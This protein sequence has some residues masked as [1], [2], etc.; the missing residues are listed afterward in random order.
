MMS[1]EEMAALDAFLIKRIQDAQEEF[2]RTDQ[3]VGQMAFG[4]MKSPKMKM[5]A[6]KGF[7]DKKPQQL[8]LADYINLCEALGLN[9]AKECREALKAVKAAGKGGWEMTSKDIESQHGKLLNKYGMLKTV[10]SSGLPASWGLCW[11]IRRGIN[12]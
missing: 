1:F 7:G 12:F 6:I 9:W 11:N 2:K 4:W 3:Q 8:R 10:M 5:Q